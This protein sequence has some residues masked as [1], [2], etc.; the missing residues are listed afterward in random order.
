MGL[1]NITGDVLR[2]SVSYVSR[3]AGYIR[4]VD[5]DFFDVIGWLS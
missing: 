2:K 4:H 3:L 5:L 1:S